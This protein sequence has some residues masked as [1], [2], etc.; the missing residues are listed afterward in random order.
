MHLA[1][2]PATDVFIAVCP[3]FRAVT[4]SLA[5]LEQSEVDSAGGVSLGAFAFERVVNPLSIAKGAVRPALLAAAVLLSV[6]EST[7]VQ[8]PV[9]MRQFTILAL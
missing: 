7:F 8:A 5:L 9:V 6:E 2:L 1:T 3:L 4:V